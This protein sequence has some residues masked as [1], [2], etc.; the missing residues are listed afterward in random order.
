MVLGLAEQLGIR[1]RSSWTRQ[2]LDLTTLAGRGSVAL[3]IRAT[4]VREP[5]ER[6]NTLHRAML[7]YAHA[8]LVRKSRSG[9]HVGASTM[10]GCP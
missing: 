3:R 9:W 2:G 4:K 5:D 1:S 8:Y 10:T 7:H 6:S